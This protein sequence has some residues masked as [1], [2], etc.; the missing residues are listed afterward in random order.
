[1]VEVGAILDA[2]RSVTTAV[3]S[4]GTTIA[5]ASAA[6]SGQ[7]HNTRHAAASVP[8]RC[9]SVSVDSRSVRDRP[10]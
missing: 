9:Q 6:G 5:A 2:M 10:R 8:S 4:G 1:M 7:R 3:A